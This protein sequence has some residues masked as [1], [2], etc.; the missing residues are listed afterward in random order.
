MAA[1]RRIRG[2]EVLVN[3]VTDLGKRQGL[4]RSLTPENWVRLVVQRRR[5]RPEKT[6]PR[7]WARACAMA[8]GAWEGAVSAA[9]AGFVASRGSGGR[10]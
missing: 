10:S 2:G 6:R 9:E 1:R 7:R 8:P 5:A 3:G 4:W